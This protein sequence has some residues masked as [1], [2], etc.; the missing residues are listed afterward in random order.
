MQ[1]SSRLFAGQAEFVKFFAAL[2]V[3]P[4]SIWKIRL[5]SSYFSKSTKAKHQARQGI[6]QI[7]RDDLCLVFKFYPSS[8]VLGHVADPSRFDADLDPT[9]NINADPD[10]SFT[11]NSR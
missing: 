8:M 11:C 2:A 5:N 9:L 3:L 6:E 4:W 7:L 10:P 1:R